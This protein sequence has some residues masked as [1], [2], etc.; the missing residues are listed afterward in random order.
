M[1]SRLGVTPDCR[2]RHRHVRPQIKDRV[3]G[4]RRYAGDR[5][6]QRWSR[7]DHDGAGIRARLRGGGAAGPRGRRRPGHARPARSRPRPGPPD[8]R[9]A[10]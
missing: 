1:W 9:R 10:G 7:Q 3:R 4:S 6:R 5:R 8:R 2:R